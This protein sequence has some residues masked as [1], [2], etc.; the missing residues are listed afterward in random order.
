MPLPKAKMTERFDVWLNVTERF[1]LPLG[2]RALRQRGLVQ[3]DF[4]G[5]LRGNRYPPGS[6]G[7]RG[8]CSSEVTAFG[9]DLDTFEGARVSSRRKPLMLFWN[10]FDGDVSE[11]ELWPAMLVRRQAGSRRLRRLCPHGL[12]QSGWPTARR[13]SRC[14]SN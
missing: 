5:A 8:C 10:W 1:C 12:K 7:T 6:I 14:F 4:V 11:K 3:F 13:A 9:S 2:E